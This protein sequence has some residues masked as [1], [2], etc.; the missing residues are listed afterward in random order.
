MWT[1]E[2]GG[3]H[4]TSGPRPPEPTCAFPAETDAMSDATAYARPTGANGD[5]LTAIGAHMRFITDAVASGTMS[6]AGTHVGTAA[7]VRRAI[8]PLKVLVAEASAVYAA[9]VAGTI[10]RTA[11]KQV[12]ARAI[13]P[14]PP[15]EASACAVAALSVT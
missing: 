11:S 9:A 8:M 7:D 3:E 6:S 13:G 2:R 15:K 14:L 5:S 4:V 12:R 1:D 10:V